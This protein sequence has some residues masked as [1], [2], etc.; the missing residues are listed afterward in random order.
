MSISIG[1]TSLS[2]DSN[3]LVKVNYEYFKS[4]AGEI[5]GGYT[6]YT[7]SG[8]ISKSDDGS[9]TGASVMSALAGI[10]DIGKTSQCLP[11]S[12]SGFYSGPAKITNVSIEQG[13]DPSWINQG[14]YTIELK[15][16]LDQTLQNSL[17]ITKDDFVTELSISESIDIGEDSHA[18]FYDGSFSKSFVKFTNKVNIKCAPL[19]PEDGTPFAK[20]LA[21]LRRVVKYGPSH[22][23]FDQYKTWN[24]YL[25]SRS[26][27]LNSDGGIS[28]SASLILRPTCAS[29]AALTDISFGYNRTYESQTKRKTISGTITGLVSVNWGDLVTLSDTCSASKL[30]S[31]EAALSQIKSRFGSLGSWQ[32]ISLELTQLPNCPNTNTTNNC[33]TGTPN[34]AQSTYVEPLSSSISKSRTDGS[35]NFS[36]EWGNTDASSDCTSGGT[37]TDVIIDITDPAPTLVQHIIFGYGTLI[38]DINCKSAKRVSGTLSITTDNDSC[39]RPSCSGVGDPAFLDAIRDATS[40][41][42]YLLIGDTETIAQS[43]YTRKLDY[44]RQCAE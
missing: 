17:G 20:A 25:Q 22:P 16:K 36:F 8:T 3:P 41:G 21:V 31:A 28:F 42:T 27:E 44:I 33:L 40:D 30:S 35:I 29:I 11:V 37:K 10:R 19:C 14:A 13:P 5:I 34:S 39:P 7:I 15:T 24:K 43:S 23:I 6:V 4:N 1:G 38:Q 2:S 9:A 12:I 26:M 18:Y 32:G